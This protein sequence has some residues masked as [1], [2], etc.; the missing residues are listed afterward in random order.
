LGRV[1]DARLS[2]V[3]DQGLIE[4]AAWHLGLNDVPEFLLS[5]KLIDA[6]AIVDND[7][8]VRNFSSGRHAVF[9]A[10]STNGE[11]YLLK[12]DPSI[13]AKTTA[14]EA[15]VYEWLSRVPPIQ[16]FIP[17]F[18]RYDAARHVL[19]L[20]FIPAATDLATYHTV[21]RPSI[22]VARAIGT[23]LAELHCVSTA[24]MQSS[25]T[26]S[27]PLALT[28][29]RPHVRMARDCSPACLNLI[30]I[31]QNTDGYGASLDELGRSW[32]ATAL[33]HRDVRLKNFLLT[34]PARTMRR[35]DVKLIDWE[36]ACVGDPRWDIGS[37]LGNYLSL[38]LESIPTTQTADL[39]QS[40]ASAKYPLSCIQPAIRACW[41]D[42]V[43]RRG[44]PSNAAKRMLV[45]TV[46]FAAARLVQIA[47]EAAQGS[48]RLMTSGVLH[49]QV[50]FNMLTR[51]EEAVAHLYGLPLT[52]DF[53]NR[54]P[55]TEA[56]NHRDA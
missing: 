44:L 10:E 53:P 11:S 25:R 43:T 52:L 32:A 3:N 15:A 41:E 30:R 22:R 42:Y 47:Y 27:R 6:R 48:I 7:L 17:Q 45:E 4:P 39:S 14:L 24:Q 50:A 40:T 31:L 36:L 28:L 37:A 34:V 2:D 33:I 26:N 29:H 56:R 12:Q 1:R 51:P 38:W 49:L 5:R 19:V 13:D 8:V 35:T 55:G 9:S 20:E 54:A 23:H 16:K 46:G 21:R 18:H